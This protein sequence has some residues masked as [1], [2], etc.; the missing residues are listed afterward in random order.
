MNEFIDNPELQPSTTTF[1]SSKLSTD[2]NVSENYIDEESL[3]IDTR[4]NKTL[5]T[6]LTKKI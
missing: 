2:S 6:Q 4:T 5:P 3:I 1:K